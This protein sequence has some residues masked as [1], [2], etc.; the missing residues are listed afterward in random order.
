MG[1]NARGCCYLVGMWNDAP[2]AREFRLSPRQVAGL[3]LIL[4][5]SLTQ[6]EAGDSA[7]GRAMR[8]TS[9]PGAAGLQGAEPA[10][11]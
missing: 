11:S 6:F 8:P 5:A 4:D 1:R 2:N 7:V 9:A 10:I 3:T